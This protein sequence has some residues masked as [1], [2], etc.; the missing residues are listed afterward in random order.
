MDVTLLERRVENAEHVEE[1]RG[2]RVASSYARRPSI[3]DPQSSAF[4]RVFSLLFSILL[5]TASGAQGQS[6]DKELL[7][8]R[9]GEGWRAA[10][11]ARILNAER[12]SSLPDA[13]VLREYGLR[14]VINRVYTDGKNESSVEV[15][16]LNLIPNAYGLYTFNRGRIPPKSREF[17]QGRYVV[18]VSNTA[19]DANSGQQIFEAIK[20][21][22]I[23]GEGELPSLPMH[24]PEKD[25]IAESEKYIIGPA[26]FSR[27]KNLGEMKDAINFD[28][29][30]EITTADYRNGGGQMSLI[31]VEYYTP[32]S[33]SEGQTRVQDYFNAFPKT[34]TQPEKGRRIFKRVGNYVVVM[35]PVQDM[36]AAENIAGQIKYQKK[37]YW[38]GKKFSD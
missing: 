22:L 35:G 37:I 28:A 10:G 32:Q 2:S 24:L 21:N 13:D 11:P 1:G 30:V 27:L 16:E 23:G 17:Y 38:A 12:L 20:P 9:L 34:G 29:G 15:F 19:A 7:P 33:A 18:R 31:I 3:F 14:R 36:A 4:F 8:D 6:N 25:K 5:L 26:A